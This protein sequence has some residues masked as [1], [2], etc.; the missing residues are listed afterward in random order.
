M[1]GNYIGKFK[2]SGM[3]IST[4][5]GSTGWLFSA[6]RFT[7]E[8]VNGTL[9]AMGFNEPVEVVKLIADGLSEDTRFP[10]SLP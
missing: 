3:I 4:G 5:T 8:E 7:T 1:N 2:S 9:K 6:K 10:P